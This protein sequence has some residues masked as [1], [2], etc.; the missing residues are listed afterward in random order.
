MPHRKL[1]PLNAVRAF[2]AAARAGGVRAAAEELGVS[3][4]AVSRHI[5]NLEGVLQTSLFLRSG[6]RLELTDTGREYLQQLEPAF[7]SIARASQRAAGERRRERLSVSA[8]PSFILNWLMPRLG[9]FMEAHPEIELRLVDRM[10]FPEQGGDVDCAIEY[11]LDTSP[12][13]R[14][15]AL[16]SDEIVP[17]AAPDYI[18][19]HRIRA[20]EDVAACTLIETERRLVSWSDILPPGPERA[21]PRVLTVGLSLHA[22]QAARLGYGIALA[23]RLNAS[24]PMR[25]GALEIPFVLDQSRLPPRPR[26]YYSVPPGRGADKERAFHD[27]LEQEL[28]AGPG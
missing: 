1:P 7:D 25:E 3:Q 6:R 5:A 15:T 26:Y 14:S 19:R 4:S 23:N 11:R 27:W 24:A 2:E 22:L 12:R 16:I 28:A 17:M 21:R 18:A 9:G 8:P 10:T 20:L 13:L